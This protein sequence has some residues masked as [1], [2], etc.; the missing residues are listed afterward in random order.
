MN[1]IPKP[2]RAIPDADR[3]CT[4][5][6]FKKNIYFPDDRSVDFYIRGAVCWPS[7]VGSGADT[8]T[9][10]CVLVG[11]QDLDSTRIFIFEQIPF[12][13]VDPILEPETKRI[14]F[15]GITHHLAA[16]WA[17]YYVDTYYWHDHSDTHNRYLI[18]LIRSPL[19]QPT[20]WFAEVIWHDKEQAEHAL[21]ELVTHARLVHFAGEAPDKGQSAP[22]YEAMLR[23]RDEKLVL[24][25]VKA[26]MVLAMGFERYP[27]RKEGE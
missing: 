26:A 6:F 24:P 16:W 23:W 18:Q 14:A 15:E 12:V 19:L 21:M 25:P 20:P 17:R 11:G 27:W 10:G 22:L 5:L 7:T 3:S 2:W 1:P 13:S 8:A 4:R 9:E